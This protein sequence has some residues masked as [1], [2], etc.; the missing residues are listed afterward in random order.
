M[1]ADDP[2]PDDVETLKQPLR[3]REAELARARAE[4]SSASA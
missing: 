3:A 1:T 4:A 2:P